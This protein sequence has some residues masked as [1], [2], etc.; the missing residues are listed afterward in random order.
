[1][2]D[3]NKEVLRTREDRKDAR[4]KFVKD[5][6]TLD[7]LRVKYLSKKG[8]ITEL[9][10]KIKEIPNEEKKDYGMKVNEIRS[11]FNDKYD[12]LKTALEKEAK[13]ISEAEALIEKQT[14]KEGQDIGEE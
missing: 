7:E 14:K 12:S 3:L 13:T 6:K 4:K 10:S 2:K 5:L 8:I 1:M 9:N 11:Y